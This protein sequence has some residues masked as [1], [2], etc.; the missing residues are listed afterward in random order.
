MSNRHGFFDGIIIGAALGVVLGFLTAPKSGEETR[1][2][3]KKFRSD[4]KD[5]IE[6]AKQ[7]TED[8]IRQTRESIDDG[9]HQLSK[10]VEEKRKEKKL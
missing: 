1:E 8:L 9:L 10:L 2:Q 6:D 4:N 5:L 3:L 7:K